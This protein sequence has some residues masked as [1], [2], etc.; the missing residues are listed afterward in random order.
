ME[1][2]RES[3]LFTGGSSDIQT[4]ARGRTI[5]RVKMASIYRTI[6]TPS[7]SCS[8]FRMSFEGELDHS[9]DHFTIVIRH[10]CRKYGSH[11]SRSSETIVSNVTSRST[12]LT[13]IEK[14][15]DSSKLITKLNRSVLSQHLES[16]SRDGILKV[17]QKIPSPSFCTGGKKTHAFKALLALQIHWGISVPL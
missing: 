4:S 3:S 12:A 16:I 8:N 2:K 17:R 5:P 1:L 13:F 7:E 14:R 11:N 9:T 10:S 15:A 6:H